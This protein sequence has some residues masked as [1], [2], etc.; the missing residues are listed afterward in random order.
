MT[1]MCKMQ[2]LTC[3]S[4]SVIPG[5]YSR[6]HYHW[7]A[8]VFAHLQRGIQLTTPRMR[9]KQ[10][11]NW[12]VRHIH[13]RFK[14]PRTRSE[15][16]LYVAFMLAI[17][18]GLFAVAHPLVVAAFLLGLFG[19]TVHRRLAHKLGQRR[20]KNTGRSSSSVNPTTIND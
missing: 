1:V 16:A 18:V 4:V 13:A 17:P 10:K 12:S 15:I 14:I 9:P 2:V 11:P 8:A 20:S 7:T 3:K 6:Y 19:R 5:W